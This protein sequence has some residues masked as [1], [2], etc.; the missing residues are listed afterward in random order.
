MKK[1]NVLK[2][3]R[4]MSG[5]TQQDI[6]DAL[7]IERSTYTKWEQKETDLTLT[8]IVRL[9]KFYGLNANAITKMI[10]DGCLS[11]P[12]VIATVINK[13]TTKATSL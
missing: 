13:K 6:A 5:F 12:D 7:K 9:A 10:L 4:V 3:L 2:Q 1:L 11:S 8:H